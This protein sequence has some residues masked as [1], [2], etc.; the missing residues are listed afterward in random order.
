MSVDNNSADGYCDLELISE[1]FKEGYGNQEIRILDRLSYASRCM[2]DFVN[3]EKKAFLD[4]Q[5]RTMFPIG[6]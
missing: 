3:L 2:Y 5:E 4:Y 1:Y 6:N